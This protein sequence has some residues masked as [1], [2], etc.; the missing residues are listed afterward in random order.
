MSTFARVVADTNVLVSRL[1]LPESVPAQI[2]RQIELSS[3]LLFS[4]S[5]MNELADVLSRQKFDR[6][7]SHD[8]RKGFLMRLGKIAEF[9]PILQ[10]VRECCD[11]KDDKFLEVALN[12]GA[13]V[14]ITGDADLLGMHPWRGVAILS[15]A[16]YLKR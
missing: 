3:L 14:I 11:P 1:I 4:E 15:P 10:Q 16:E 13:D 5:T 9:V 12:G 7:V 2:L 6:Y 8:D